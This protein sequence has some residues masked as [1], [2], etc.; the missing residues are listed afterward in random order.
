MSHE[1][2]FA[3]SLKQAKTYGIGE[4]L[5]LIGELSQESTKKGAL[6]RK[7]KELIT[8]GI[9]LAKHC[10]R[11]IKIHTRASEALGVTEEEIRQVRK[12]YLFLKASPGNDDKLLWKSWKDSWQQFVLSK[13]PLESHERELIALGIALVKQSAEHIKLHTRCAGKYSATP[14]QIFEVMPIALLMDGAPALSQ[15]PRLMKALED[16][17]KHK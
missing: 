12:I 13:G 17:K 15:I 8:L 11:C 6:S 4:F 7:E 10:N 1:D 14:Q 2:T 16:V 9:A 3:D 5:E